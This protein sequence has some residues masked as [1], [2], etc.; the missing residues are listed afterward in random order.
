MERVM[1]I[2]VHK[3]FTFF[4][5]LFKSYLLRNRFVFFSR[6]VFVSKSGKKKKKKTLLSFTS[7]SVRRTDFPLSPRVL[8][9]KDMAVKLRQIHDALQRE[10]MQKTNRLVDMKRNVEERNSQVW[11]TLLFEDGRI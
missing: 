7:L 9:A 8:E 3:Y 11:A 6:V 4:V 1:A 10:V 2:I 5:I